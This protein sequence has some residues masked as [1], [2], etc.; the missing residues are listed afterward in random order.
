[1]TYA[2]LL[3]RIVS[4]LEDSKVA[5]MV[6]GSVA[7]SFH[8]KPRATFDLDIVI[9][10]TKQQL[11]EFLIGLGDE[12]YVSSAA[13]REAFEQRGMF[14]VVD[15][16]TGIKADLILRKNR[17][18]SRTEFERKRRASLLNV[19]CYV[20]TAEDSILSK[21]EWSKL[22]ASDRQLSDVIETCRANSDLDAEYLRDWAEQLGVADLLSQVLD[23]SGLP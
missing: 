17:D 3:G 13:A 9:D 5:Y 21:L 11:E 7:S 20:V 18:F 12:Y 2:N 23:A 19:D 6:T 1:V 14:N 4:L 16:K 8:G 10:P 22:A 15:Y